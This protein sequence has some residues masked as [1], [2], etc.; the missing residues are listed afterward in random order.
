MQVDI[1]WYNPAGLT[2]EATGIIKPWITRNVPKFLGHSHEKLGKLSLV[3]TNKLG[4]HTAFW[5]REKARLS[6]ISLAIHQPEIG[7]QNPGA[8]VNTKLAGCSTYQ[9][10]SWCGFFAR[11]NPSPILHFFWGHPSIHLVYDIGLLTLGGEAVR[12]CRWLSW[13]I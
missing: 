13:F 5:S 10:L 7:G 8:L 3:L 11:V 2:L 6:I 1:T 9:P 4:M 12:P